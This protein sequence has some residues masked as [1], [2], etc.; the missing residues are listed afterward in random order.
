ML[1]GLV[2][3]AA[4]GAPTTYADILARPP[5]KATRRIAYDIGPDQFGDLWL[6]DGPGNH[7]VVVLIHGGCWQASLPGV[8][9]MNYAADDLRQ[10]GFAV[11]NLE[12]RRLGDGGGYPDTF[13][14]IAAGL[15]KLRTLAPEYRLDLKHV[16]L[17][18]HSAGGALALWAAARG[19]LPP[20]SPLLSIDPLPV[21]GVVT[22]GG[23][24][25]LRTYRRAGPDAC[26]G[27][28][29]IDALLRGHPLT[30]D[31]FADTSPA[32]LLPIGAPQTIVAGDADLIVPPVFAADYAAKAKAAGDSVGTVTL[33]D[34]G[35]FDLIDPLAAAW[36]RIEPLIAE[37]AR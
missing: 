22:L 13:R 10:R 25:D 34:A 1:I 32:A 36:R 17:V 12:Y 24:D 14:D 4:P 37:R 19:H 26:G 27:P 3:A 2:P 15:D 6:P 7:P 20:K 23:I 33:P 5:L 31:A 11:W 8:E 30:A 21:A 9:L 18:G 28:E 16:V 35:H 29:T